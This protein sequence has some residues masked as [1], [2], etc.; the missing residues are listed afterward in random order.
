M[1]RIELVVGTRSH[2]VDG[3]TVVP[4]PLA[5]SRICSY[6]SSSFFFPRSFNPELAVA[7]NRTMVL[8]KGQP[9]IALAAPPLAHVKASS[10][11][12]CITRPDRNDL[13][14]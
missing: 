2:S 7:G 3:I 5:S 13:Y 10:A 14:E 9:R 8:R 1:T 6:Q 4:A 12:S 11:S